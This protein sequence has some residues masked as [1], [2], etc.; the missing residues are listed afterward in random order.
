MQVRK[1]PIYEFLEVSGKT[2]VIPVYQR[3][4]AW[5]VE[6]YKK[7]NNSK[8][9]KCSHVFGLT[10]RKRQCPCLFVPADGERHFGGS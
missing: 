1:E 9:S 6:N 8:S 2:F 4:Y 7:R 10:R 3:D 5:R